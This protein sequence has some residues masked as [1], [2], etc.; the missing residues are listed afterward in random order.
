MSSKPS[1]T[2]AEAQRKL[3]YYCAYQ[4]RCHLEVQ[5][6]LKA[7]GMIP[8]A[9]EQIISHLIANNYLNE[10]RFAQSF[11]RGK[12]R[13]KKWGKERIIRELQLRQISPYNVKLALKEIDPKAYLETLETLATKFWNS[14]AT[15]SLS[16]C[17]K[18]V[19]DALKYRGWESALIWER[20]NELEKKTNP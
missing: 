8:A 10:S 19:H 14:N 3:E 7:F 5:T 17:K 1:Y 16:V 12:F 6:K 4:D 18:K 9:Q 2:V 20:I 15:K 13:M 11:A